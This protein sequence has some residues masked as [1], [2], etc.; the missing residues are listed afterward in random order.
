MSQ[1]TEQT[2]QKNTPGSEEWIEKALAENRVRDFVASVGNQTENQEQE[3]TK[4]K[5]ELF[6][7]IY[8]KT[9]GTITVACEKADIGRTTFYEWKKYDPEFAERL[10]DIEQQRIDM[11]EDRV[12]KLIQQD[13]GPTVRWFLERVSDKYKSKKVL[14]H[15]TDD[16]TF[17]DE[18]DEVVDRMIKLSHE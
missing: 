4:R 8:E 3:R 14:E 13:D 1:E 5:K 9:M 15:H 6:L 17:E 2:E 11:A 18:I 10:H 12:F 7:D 16:K